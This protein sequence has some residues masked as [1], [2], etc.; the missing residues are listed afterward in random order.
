MIDDTLFY[1]GTHHEH[2]LGFAGVPLF[3]SHRRLARRRTFPRA[4]AEWALDSGGFSELSLY[5]EWRTS[6]AAYVAA[7]RRYDDEIG[8]LGWAAPQDWM[9]EPVMLER[10]GLT[11]AEH[12]RR[13]V[14]NYVVLRDLW[15][16]SDESPDLARTPECCPFMPVLQGWTAD[17]YLRCAEMYDAAGV[18]LSHH[19]I[20]GIGSVCRRQAT[21]EIRDVISRVKAELD[22][23]LHGFGVKTDGLAVYGPDL[24]AADSMA[25]SYAARRRPPLPGCTA[26]KNCANCPRFA[27]GWRTRVLEVLNGPAPT[28]GNGAVAA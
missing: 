22:V 27:L 23:D 13:T 17:D 18:T 21:T 5:G 16:G 7:V 12:Q 8:M 20:V 11:V 4:I 26:H 9:C 14:E 19:P 25:W 3:V 2:W 10:T 1:L 24:R 15:A 6:P 28:S